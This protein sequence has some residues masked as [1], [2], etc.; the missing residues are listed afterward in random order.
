MKLL[1]IIILNFLLI[2]ATACANKQTNEN[3]DVVTND[4][5]IAITT[6]GIADSF[7]KEKII[8]VVCKND[9][10][11]SY[12]LYIPSAK[13]N[14]IV[15]FFDAHGDGSLPLK[16]YKALANAYHFI[17]I[18]SNNS[19]NGNDWPTTET[20]WQN[21]FNDSQTRLALNKPRIYVCGFSGGAKVAGYIALHHNEIKGVIANSAGLPDETP[22]GNFNFSFT[23]IAG[24]GDMN[25]TDIVALNNELDKTQTAHRIIFF[26]GKHEWAPLSVLN[27]AFQGLQLDAMRNNL[28]VKND[29][30]INAYISNSKKRLDSVIHKNDLIQAENE[31]ILS[32]N[33]LD[34]IADVN[35]FK[36]KDNAIKNEPAYKKQLQQEQILFTTEQNKKA[37]YNNEFQK[38]DM[39]YWNKTINDLTIQSKPLT[40][41]GAMYE[42]LLAYLSLAFYSISNQLINNNQNNDAAYFVNLYKMA[43]PSNSEAWYFSA[44]LDARNNNINAVND[45]LLKAVEN[46]F[47]DTTRMLNQSEFLRLQPQINFAAIRNKMK[48]N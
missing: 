8:R 19:K 27:I 6:S 38:G 13:A 21:L 42:R 17:F 12:A 9:P 28:V 36:E 33:M 29:S 43:D 22:A 41:E 32:I 34:G 46:N 39:S 16:N 10:S 23:G 25:M 3:A 4:T 45:D 37:E 48:H 1:Q 2:A 26:N 15:Y 18:G 35:W 44:I 30:L 5:T 47:I 31:C 20:I 14:T 40:P 24:K 11:Q 7:P